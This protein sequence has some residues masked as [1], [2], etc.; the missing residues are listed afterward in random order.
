MEELFGSRLRTRVLVLLALVGES[1]PTQIARLLD[2]RQLPVQRVVNKLE[3]EGVLSSRL[4][5]T[6][7]LVTLNPRFFAF[8]Q[9]RA[10]LLKMGEGNAELMDIASSLRRR[11]RR[12]GKPLRSA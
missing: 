10:L 4:V 2:S 6:V 7:R 9:L 5:G 11:P 8:A 1:Y 3:L 12:A